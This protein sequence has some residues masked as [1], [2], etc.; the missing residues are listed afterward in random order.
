[1]TAHAPDTM[2]TDSDHLLKVNRHRILIKD[3][4]QKGFFFIATSNT[5]L[6]F[7]TVLCVV[8]LWPSLRSFQ[9]FSSTRVT[10][11]SWRSTVLKEGNKCQEELHKLNEIMRYIISPQPARQTTIV[12]QGHHTMVIGAA[13]QSHI[14]CSPSYRRFSSITHWLMIPIWPI[15]YRWWII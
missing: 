4:R 6:S 13:R 7:F 3:R 9:P 5:V 10:C 2:T 15:S 12:E 14:F 11:V 8:A 1:M